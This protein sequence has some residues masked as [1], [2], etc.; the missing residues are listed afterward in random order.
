MTLFN[1]T[2]METYYGITDQSGG[3]CGT[4]NANQTVDLPAYDNKPSVTV[5]FVAVG[6][7]APGEYPPFS[8]MIPD[9]G[10]GTTVTIGLY[11]E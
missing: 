3:D 11:Q 8:V 9:T 4:I 6:K 1:N 10:T 5:K 7:A 2:P